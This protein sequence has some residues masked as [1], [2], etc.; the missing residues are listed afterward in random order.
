[1]KQRI[2]LIGLLSAFLVWAVCAI[3]DAG[4]QRR[5]FFEEGRALLSDYWMPRTCVDEGYA[6]VGDKFL[7]WFGVKNSGWVDGKM[8][9][10]SYDRCY[11]P[12]ALLPLRAFP[13]T[14]G[15]AW[16]WTILST[17]ALIIVLCALARSWWPLVLLGSMPVLFNL[18][19][20]NPIVLAAAL[21]GVFLA[22][23]RSEVRWK[24]TVAALA[25]SAAVC[26]KVSPVVLGALYLREKD[27]RSI[28]LC[29]VFTS[30]LFFVPWFF[31]PDGLSGLSMMLANAHENGRFYIRLAEFG[32]VAFWRTLRV[33]F[34]QDCTSLW[35]GCQ[36]VAQLS[37]VIGLLM[38]GCGAWKR[39]PLLAIV[40]ML[41][42][43]GNMHYYGVLYLLPILVLAPPTSIVS[44]CLWFAILCPLQLVYAGHSGN[45]VLCNFCILPLCAVM[46]KERRVG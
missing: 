8:R 14:W 39:Q 45:A 11:P 28:G 10:V 21:V 24:R 35:P 4:G 46:A 20:G 44:I 18:E 36:L 16:A 22:W 31:M 27:W 42:A 32:L 23:Y 1:M 6:E 37:R 13:A 12:L 19:R 34:H 5:L 41:W 30:V 40:G 17:L 25:L 26:F 15:G 29:V 9:V 33:V 2:A 7:V 3:T 43:A 38:I